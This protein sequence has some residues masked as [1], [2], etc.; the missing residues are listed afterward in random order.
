MIQSNYSCSTRKEPNRPGSH[1]PLIVSCLV[2]ASTATTVEF[3]YATFGALVV[4]HT[5]AELAL[6]SGRQPPHCLIRRDTPSSILAVNRV[7]A[8]DKES[9]QNPKRRSAVAPSMTE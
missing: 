1:P 7:A 5:A 9:P 3:A 4:V 2:S 8:N 6:S